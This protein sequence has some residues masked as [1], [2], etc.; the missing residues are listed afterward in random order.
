M[1]PVITDTKDYNGFYE[2]SD[3]LD[4]RRYIDEVKDIIQDFD[5][6]VK[7]EKHV[8]GTRGIRNKIDE[9]FTL[10]GGWVKAVT[11]DIDWV[12]NTEDGRSM[13][14]EVQVSGRSD[15]LAVDVLHLA[16]A[17]GGGKIDIG[18]IVVPDDTLSRYLTDR[19]PNFRTA[20]KHVDQ[21]GNS[22]PILIISFRHDG[23]GEPLAKAV[24]NLG[25]DS[26]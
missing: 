6:F 23:V 25:K 18:I 9:R 26:K 11:G 24:T 16:E 10:A 14:V 22:L 4:L 3:R 1:M 17:I 13:G 8:N 7:E 15:M 12:K 2:K 19:T 5:L 20:V 21:R